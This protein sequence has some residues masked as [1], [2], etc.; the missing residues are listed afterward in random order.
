MLRNCTPSS[1]P[2]FSTG[3]TLR[4]SAETTNRSRCGGAESSS[5]SSRF[6]LLILFQ[7][8]ASRASMP[9]RQAAFAE[10]QQFARDWRRTAAAKDHQA[11]GAVHAN[12]FASV[13]FHCEQYFPQIQTLNTV[14]RF[15][16]FEYSAPEI[17]DRFLAYRGATSIG[18]MQVR[19]MPLCSEP[20]LSH[21]KGARPRSH[22]G[23]TGLT[24]FNMLSENVIRNSSSCRA[25]AGRSRRWLAKQER[26]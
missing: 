8:P 25:E 15:S 23:M 12:R 7:M 11:G 14:T 20:V 9:R 18:K 10:V 17:A 6:G 22:T 26:S 5:S 4:M 1:M 24:R 19:K 13:F 21:H 2:W 3:R 16:L